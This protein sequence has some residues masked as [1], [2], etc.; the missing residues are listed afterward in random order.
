MFCKVLYFK[1][2]S[3]FLNDLPF[4]LYRA[5]RKVYKK[6]RTRRG[7]FGN[8]FFLF[9]SVTFSKHLHCCDLFLL[10][11]SDIIIKSTLLKWK[12]GKSSRALVVSSNCM[13]RKEE[14]QFRVSS[15]HTR[16]EIA[17]RRHVAVARFDVHFFF[18]PSTFRAI[19]AKRCE[20]PAKCQPKSF[21]FSILPSTICIGCEFVLL[22]KAPH[23][24]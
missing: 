20:D 4:G 14:N 18:F 9:P 12:R 6:K 7:N 10:S 11:G 16:W 2:N 17:E 19:C 22:S 5:H 3:A 15:P 21:P 1:I 23:H 8:K 24:L 13:N